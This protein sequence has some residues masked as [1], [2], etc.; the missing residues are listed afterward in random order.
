[1]DIKRKVLL[2][3]KNSIGWRT[4]RKIV[5]FSIDDYGNVRLNSSKAREEMDKAGMKIHS[6]FDALDTLETKTDLEML[7]EALM[8]VTD[9]NGNYAVFT[10]FALPCNINFE[11]VI[12]TGFQEYAYELLPETYSKLSTLQP[13]AYEGAWQ[14]WQEGINKGIF[15]PQFHGREHLNL[16]IFNEKLKNNDHDIITAIQNR[17]YTSIENNLYP[18]I[19]YTAAYQFWDYADNEYFKLN[20]RDGFD[21]FEKVFGY[22]P[23]HFNAPGGYEHESLHK[24]VKELGGKYV[25][26][27]WIKKEHQGLGKYK[28]RLNYTGKKED[29]G[30]T[31]M[32]RNV[33]F[34][35]SD[36][37]GFDWVSYTMKQIENAFLFR[38]PAIIS[39][40]RVN[41]CGHINENNRLTGITALKELLKRIQQRWPDVEFMSADQLF[42]I[43][44]THS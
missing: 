42:S 38:K 41:F 35:P 39:S 22:K 30:L 24:T 23:V 9:K 15:L 6:R 17:S 28:Y 14:M 11:K 36:D 33:V 37:R 32:V 40:H 3:L 27:Q 26:A 2:S 31:V 7:Y 5:V 1:M 20:I 4:N 10:P 34:E 12:E 43:I 21:A 16:R 29:S 8:S 13:A 44:T 18:T 19:G 25:D